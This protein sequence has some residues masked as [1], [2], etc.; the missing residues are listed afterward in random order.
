ERI[1]AIMD[2]LRRTPPQAVGGIAVRTI[3]DCMTGE[4]R[5]AAGAV[6]DRYDLPRSNVILLTLEDRS[7]VIARPS[8]T[9]P[10]IKFY[11]L[12]REAGSDLGAARAAATDKVERILADISQWSG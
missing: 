10:K 11:I 9:E 2:T 12:V 4:V 8:G 7:R 1:Q 5:D 3:G 6:V